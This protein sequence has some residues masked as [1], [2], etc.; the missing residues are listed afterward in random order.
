MRANTTHDRK[1]SKVLNLLHMRVGRPA[2][3]P[4]CLGEV[5]RAEEGCER[6]IGRNVE[7]VGKGS[8]S[9]VDMDKLVTTSRGRGRGLRATS[10]W[11]Q[12]G[13]LLSMLVPN[14]GIRFTD[15]RVVSLVRGRAHG[16]TAYTR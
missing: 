2:F 3:G 8:E 1:K 11:T 7:R 9:Y 10:T 12:C 15:G 4:A 16:A 14:L 5:L 13:A 6:Q